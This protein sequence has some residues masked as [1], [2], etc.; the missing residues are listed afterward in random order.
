MSPSRRRPTIVG[1]NTSRL[2]G[3]EYRA[4]TSDTHTASNFSPLQVT[5]EKSLIECGT[6]GIGPPV[7]LLPGRGGSAPE[8]FVQLGTAL[9]GAGFRAIALNPRGVGASNGSLDDLS[10]HDLADDV[11]AVIRS[12]GGPAHIVGR[13]LGN[14]IARCVA[15]DHPALVKSLSL[16]SAGGLVPP[17]ARHTTTNSPK[18]RWR[19]NHWRQAGLAH[20][21]AAQSTPLVEWWSGGEAPILVIQGQ[22]DHIAVPENGRR[23]AREFPNRVR[24]HEIPGT[25][26]M[27]L[28][29]RPDLVIPIVLSFISEI[30]EVDREKL[31]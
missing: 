8:Q 19:L 24:L 26:H 23:L 31:R 10:L 29:E 9:A 2:P 14:R 22:D 17:A 30:E 11:A 4:I 5:A 7:I 16:I 18:Q 6:L 13:A 21:Y 12:V 25:G 3:A 28:F 27:V 20:E 1:S 15:V